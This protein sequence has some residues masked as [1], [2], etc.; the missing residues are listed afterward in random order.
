MIRRDMSEQSDKPAQ[1]N[2][3]K[4]ADTASDAKTGEKHAKSSNN[5]ATVQADKGREPLRATT[6]SDKTSLDIPSSEEAAAGKPRKSNG[7]SKS[8]VTRGAQK[9]TPDEGLFGTSQPDSQ[10]VK[11]KTP[12]SSG[13]SVSRADSSKTETSK[14]KQQTKASNSGD[15]KAAKPKD[16]S[17]PKPDAH[18]SKAVKETGSDKK[19][20]ADKKSSSGK[21]K[22][23]ATDDKS[24][25]GGKR[26]RAGAR[27]TSGGDATIERKPALTT[28]TPIRKRKSDGGGG[29]AVLVALLFVLVAAGYY[30]LTQTGALDLAKEE[31]TAPTVAATETEDTEPPVTA[32]ETAEP[33]GEENQTTTDSTEVS[34][35]GV[36]EENM[37]QTPPAATLE[38]PAEEPLGEA[39]QTS[40]ISQDDKNPVPGVS[41]S[42][43]EASSSEETEV[44]TE[45][46]PTP[47]ASESVPTTAPET[48]SETG[49]VA[50][51]ETAAGN[52]K[53][54]ETASP[55]VVETAESEIT[56]TM[57]NTESAV[58]EVVDPALPS[59]LTA[60]GRLEIEEL[61]IRLQIDPG[62]AD[63]VID[64]QA[65]VAIRLYQEIAGLPVDGK[66]SPELLTELREVVELLSNE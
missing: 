41:E 58:A 21:D 1:N 47:A 48:G 63:G 64:N 43:S 53:T 57:A 16:K 8:T 55:A 36:A 33:A 2:K 9:K 60:A 24:K 59:E 50:A 32:A 42:S 19:S 4:T 6:P 15:N 14:G 28:T 29:L 35:N 13:T 46:E 26:G 5:E 34:E 23:P 49:E 52:A 25:I 17:A 56:T 37:A 22:K 11:G 18:P 20:A 31:T 40:A 45:S 62:P 39:S 10:D 51:L 27:V 61:L 44:A 30:F 54:L 38:T 66:A 65:S 12:P 3:T 7:R